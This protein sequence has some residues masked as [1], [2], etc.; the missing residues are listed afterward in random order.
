MTT[1]AKVLVLI[2]VMT[3]ALI[4]MILNLNYLPTEEH[5]TILQNYVNTVFYSVN[6]RLLQSNI[7]LGLIRARLAGALLAKGEVIVVM[8]SHMEVQERWYD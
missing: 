7:Q 5:K 8:D 3:S 4:V 1:A 2:L 6:I